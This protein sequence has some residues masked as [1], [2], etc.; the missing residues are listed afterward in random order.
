MA[1]FTI[2]IN[3]LRNGESRSV[4]Q[5]Q[6]DDSSS[7]LLRY[8]HSLRFSWIIYFIVRIRWIKF[9][10]QTISY[11]YE[12]KSY[13]Y[14][15]LKRNFIFYFLLDKYCANYTPNINAKVGGHVRIEM[16]AIQGREGQRRPYKEESKLAKSTL[17]TRGHPLTN[18]EPFFYFRI[19]F[20]LK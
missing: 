1:I 8:S 3:F 4:T 6:H 2:N 17:L 12:I 13:I 14:N 9:D 10:S 18:S 20:V 19:K 7:S 16:S 11:C 5:L 15:D